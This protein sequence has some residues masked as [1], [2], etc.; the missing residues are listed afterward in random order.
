[1]YN[2]QEGWL[3]EEISKNWQCGTPK[4]PLIPGENFHFRVAVLQKCFEIYV[5]DK[6]YGTFEHLDCHKTINFALITGDF[7]KI[8][9]FHHRMLFPLIFPRCL[10]SANT[11][12]LCFQSDVPQ[13]Y[14]TG[15]NIEICFKYGIEI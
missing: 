4:N 12:K 2:P 3:R 6:L 13:K 15:P 14:E 11:D 7:E 10:N 9:Q 5:N 8:T 1:M